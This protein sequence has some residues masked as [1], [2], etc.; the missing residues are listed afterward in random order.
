[1]N[2]IVIDEGKLTGGKTAWHICLL[3]KEHGLLA[4]PTH[5]NVIRLAPPLCISEE[6]LIRG[7]KIIGNGICC[8]FTF[9]PG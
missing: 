7:A 9:S 5:D 2:A 3:L 6:E 8:F 4:K 1:L